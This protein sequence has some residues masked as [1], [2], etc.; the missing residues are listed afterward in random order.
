V[1]RFGVGG[2]AGRVGGCGS[3]GV[4]NSD[5]CSSPVEDRTLREERRANNSGMDTEDR[6]GWESTNSATARCTSESGTW[7]RAVLVSEVV[8]EAEGLAAR[9]SAPG[10]LGVL[11]AKMVD[12]VAAVEVEGAVAVLEVI[13]RLMGSSLSSAAMSNWVDEACLLM[14]LPR[15]S[16]RRF[17]V[18][19]DIDLAA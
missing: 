13:E 4:D 12:E 2:V 16:L 14:Y 9:G 7:A 8:S 18:G 10:K 11:E 1:E 5:G 3:V 15:E 17:E 6:C 19:P